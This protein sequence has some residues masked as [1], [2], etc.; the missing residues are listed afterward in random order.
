MAE[1]EVCGKTGEAAEAC[2]FQVACS[3]WYGRPCEAA[4][5]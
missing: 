4:N 5:G 1:C 3:C 2:E